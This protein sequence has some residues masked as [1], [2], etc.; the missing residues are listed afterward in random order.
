MEGTRVKY[1]EKAIDHKRVRLLQKTTGKDRTKLNEEP[2]VFQWVRLLQKTIVVDRTIQEKKPFEF[3]WIKLMDQTMSLQWANS[4][5]ETD[6][7]KRAKDSLQNTELTSGPGNRIKPMSRRRA[8]STK[9]TK[10]IEWAKIS[11]KSMHIGRA[12]LI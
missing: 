8:N 7:W 6:R 4:W 12:I 1:M 5:E 2:I 3:E 10:Q 9:K 11:M